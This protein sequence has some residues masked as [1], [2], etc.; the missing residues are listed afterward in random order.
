M[1]DVSR[2][3]QLKEQYKQ[4]RPDMGV[5]VIRSK[6]TGKV[7]VEAAKDLRG[8]MNGS[9]FKLSAGMHRNRELQRDWQRYGADDFLVEVLDKLP[10]SKDETKTDYDDDLAELRDMWVDK[11]RHDATQLYGD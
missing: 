6:T 9:T 1:T 4:A 7:Y 8:A 10:Y 3:K 2:R 11:L 5:F